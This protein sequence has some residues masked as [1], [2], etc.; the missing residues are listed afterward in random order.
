MIKIKNVT[1][2]N[3]LSIG[4]QTQSVNF[5][6]TD[7]TLVLGE[8]QDTG[9][10]DA[11]SRNGV[12]KTAILNALSYALYGDALTSIKRENLINKTNEKHMLVTVEFELNGE[13][14]RIERGRRPGILKFYVGDHEKTPEDD[15]SQGD[16]RETQKEIDRLL[17]M[18]HD[19]F[20]H[21]VALNTYTIPFL[22]LRNNDQR[23]IIE[24]LL[25]IT[26]LSEKAERLKEQVKQTKTLIQEEEYE[27]K[28]INDSNARLEEQIKAIEKRQRIWLKNHNN[29]I[30]DLKEQLEE[31]GKIDIDQE[32]DNHASIQQITEKNRER[33][34]VLGWVNNCETAITRLEKEHK[35]LEKELDKISSS[36]C[37]SCGQKIHG[38][39]QQE[40]E[41]A[42]KR[43]LAENVDNTESEQMK[44]VSYNEQLASLGD[45]EDMPS[46]FYKDITQA[47]D[48]KNTIK[49]AIDQLEKLESK[50]D[51]Y[52]EQ[53]E[54]MKQNAIKEIDYTKINELKKVQDHQDFLH[55]LL[56]NK[57]SFIRKKIIDQ[58]LSYLNSRLLTYLNKLGLPHTVE[59]KN[60]L[61]VEIQ[62][63]GRDLDF[64]NLSRGERN[65]LILSL[66]FA[67]RDV[68]E[69]LFTPI[70]MLF[71]DEL[72]DSGMDGQGVEAAISI[73]KQMGR[74]RNKSVWLISHRD[75][76]SSRVNNILWVIKTGGFTEYSTD[77]VIEE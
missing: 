5:D 75:E 24:Q 6:R 13:D 33:E 57:D 3:F 48:H 52:M 44:L 20:K 70:N 77:T 49:Y 31:L 46:V 11:N 34:S 63:L 66:S 8:N 22:S 12:G 73:L 43:L 2:K 56:T 61:T 26:Q 54:E 23:E 29:D 58:N 41:E 16:S 42:K 19:M 4:N 67:F 68:W 60:D 28:S 47:Q 36:L 76:L 18:S 45:L 64:D 21:I 40:L 25:G 59:F 37:H 39:Q 65:R 27:I 35:K 53:I 71:I 51:P 50:E 1:A 14:Y 7:M 30:D 9:G 55:R 69:N 72:V 38:E 17:G 74:E 32:I 10:T 15:N 62:D